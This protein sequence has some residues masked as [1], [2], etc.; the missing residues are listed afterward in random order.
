MG[1]P[2]NQR[3][4]KK[5]HGNTWKWKHN[6]P[7]SLGCSKSD[8]KREVYSNTGV[9]QEGRKNSNEKPNL[10]PN[11]TRKRRT[12]TKSRNYKEIIKIRAEINDI[13]TKTKQN[14]KQ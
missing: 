1:Q 11:R 9:P 4:N 3:R 10:I 8:S 12:K 6:G 13:G 14:K 2:G 7:K 5:L